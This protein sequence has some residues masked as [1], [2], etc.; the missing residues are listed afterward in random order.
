MVSWPSICLAQQTSAE[1]P[2]EVF[3]FCFGAVY[4]FCFLN[5]VDVKFRISKQIIIND[6][7]KCNGKIKWIEIKLSGLLSSWEV[8]SHLNISLEPQD[9]KY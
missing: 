6:C 2:L 5:A 3:L 8:A 1:G 4:L 9:E 7:L